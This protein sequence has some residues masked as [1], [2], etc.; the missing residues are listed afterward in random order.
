MSTYTT[1]PLV[2]TSQSSNMK[3]VDTGATTVGL[4]LDGTITNI[5]AYTGTGSWPT[6]PVGTV[7]GVPDEAEWFEAEVSLPAG[8]AWFS[9]EGSSATDITNRWQFDFVRIDGTDGSS[10]NVQPRRLTHNYTDATQT[11]FFGP[12]MSFTV[13]GTSVDEIETVNGGPLVLRVRMSLQNISTSSTDTGGIGQFASLSVRSGVPPVKT[14]RWVPYGAAWDPGIDIHPFRNATSVD[15]RT[16]KGLY[17]DLFETPVVDGQSFQEDYIHP[18]V[19]GVLRYRTDRILY[20]DTV[21]Q[22][23]SASL[24]GNYAQVQMK[25]ER[26]DTFDLTG[27]AILSPNPV[28]L[29]VTASGLYGKQLDYPVGSS[30]IERSID[31]GLTWMP[32]VTG[33]FGSASI[34]AYIDLPPLNSTVSYRAWHGVVAADGEGGYDATTGETVDGG[35]GFDSGQVAEFEVAADTSVTAS[36]NWV[37]DAGSLQMVLPVGSVSVLKTATAEAVMRVDGSSVIIPGPV[38][39]AAY[40]LTATILDTDILAVLE[41]IIKHDQILIRGPHGERSWVQPTGEITRT[42]LPALETGLGRGEPGKL[43]ET[44]WLGQCTVRF[45]ED[46]RWDY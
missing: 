32:V 28:A 9:I 45:M 42:Q 12:R 21:Y 26:S 34:S 20:P 24:F 40:T 37:I 29:T 17:V 3:R 8:S 36:T 19:S 15:W 10:H 7:G 30:S 46:Q 13:N 5:Y 4:S 41:Q 22:M 39:S 33:Y 43:A 38:T 31:G 44:S 27:S 35:G 16:A 1:Y 14:S 23:E 25:E 18:P 6:P 2:V 11:E